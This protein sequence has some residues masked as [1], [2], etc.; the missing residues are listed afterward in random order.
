MHLTWYFD[1][2]SPFSYLHWQKV[3]ALLPDHDITLVPVVFAGVLDAV[4][5]KGPA[6]IPGKREF[7][8]R[9]VLWQA[10]QEGV[11]LRFPPAH[12]FNPLAALRL[13]IAAGSTVEAV[14][15]V[16]DWIW[17]QGR[18]G[19][20]IEALAPLLVA[21]NVPAEA[22]VAPETKAALR[23]NTDAAIAAGVYGVPTLAFDGQMF[24]GNDAHEFAL[25]ALRDPSL[26]DDPGMQHASQLPVGL[27]RRG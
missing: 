4:G 19:D 8:Y 14:D 17:A 20:S 3:K 2:I 27:Q 18:A 12:P 15:S 11:T 7:T 1:F 22:L 24:W 6:E 10:R 9:H 5:Q 26:L 13:A 25:A 21:L 23:E 16:F